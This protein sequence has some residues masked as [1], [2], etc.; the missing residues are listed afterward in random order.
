MKRLV[1][2]VL[3]LVAPRTASTRRSGAGERRGAR[4][5]SD[6]WRQGDRVSH[7]L[8]ISPRFRSSH[9]LPRCVFTAR[10][11]SEAVHARESSSSCD[12]WLRSVVFSANARTEAKAPHKCVKWQNADSGKQCPTRAKVFWV[13]ATAGSRHRRLRSKPFHDGSAILLKKSRSARPRPRWCPARSAR[14]LTWAP[15][16]RSPAACA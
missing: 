4:G 11:S 9:V 2:N 3:E 5:Q 1:R 13:V 7:R 15:T 8:N 6:S 10:T 12:G 16:T 14:A